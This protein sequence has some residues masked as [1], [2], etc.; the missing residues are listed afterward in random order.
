MYSK[1][2]RFRKSTSKKRSLKN[3]KRKSM[4]VRK[5]VFRLYR[6]KFVKYI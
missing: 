3:V 6:N 4:R 5:P 1:K 2:N